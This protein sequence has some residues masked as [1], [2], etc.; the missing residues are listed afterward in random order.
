MWSGTLQLIKN[1]PFPYAPPPP[2]HG[3]GLGM[4]I[5]EDYRVGLGV[6]VRSKGST[7]M[8]H[9]RAEQLPPS[10]PKHADPSS[11][12]WPG[13]RLFSWIKPPRNV[14]YTFRKLQQRLAQLP[15]SRCALI[16]SLR[17]RSLALINPSWGQ[18]EQ[19]GHCFQYPHKTADFF[20]SSFF[21]I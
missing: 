7:T 2:E 3:F 5:A 14:T 21:P 6:K 11:A 20:Y 18:G 17:W 19:R 16:L 12:L 8:C 13:L 9:D 1:E 4:H 10:N 15:L